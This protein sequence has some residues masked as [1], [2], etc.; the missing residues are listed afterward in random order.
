MLSQEIVEKRLQFVENCFDC[1]QLLVT[2]LGIYKVE[3]VGVNS[4]FFGT[5]YHTVSAH[6]FDTVLV[7]G[8]Y[9]KYIIKVMT[10]LKL[11]FVINNVL[12]I[13]KNL[14][15]MKDILADV[16]QLQKQQ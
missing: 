10:S 4:V 7:H 5:V 1:L 11:T 13:Q 2:Y 15:I 16:L 12:R 8:I 14:S 9:R 6:D 3:T